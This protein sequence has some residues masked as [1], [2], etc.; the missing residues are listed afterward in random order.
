MGTF[1]DSSHAN[2]GKS[3]SFCHMHTSTFF[4]TY[5]GE[6][7]ILYSVVDSDPCSVVLP[8]VQR[9]SRSSAIEYDRIPCLAVDSDVLCRS[10]EFVVRTTMWT[11]GSRNCLLCHQQYLKQEQYQHGDC[12]RP[13]DSQVSITT[14]DEDQGG[15]IK[16]RGQGRLG[17]EAMVFAML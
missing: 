3:V 8:H 14:R 16:A 10:N 9:R 12:Q 2:A 4:A 11:W 13:A 17:F 7:L 15:L 6:I 1:V 5:H